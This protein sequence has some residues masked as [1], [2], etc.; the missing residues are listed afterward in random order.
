VEKALE[1]EMTPVWVNLAALLPV[2]L[3]KANKVALAQHLEVLTPV[4]GVEVEVVE[5]PIPVQPLKPPL[6]V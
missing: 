4:L 3:I 5:V 2:G 1:L 6:K